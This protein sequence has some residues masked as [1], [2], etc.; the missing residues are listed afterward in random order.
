MRCAASVSTTLEGTTHLLTSP[1][2]AP[3][4]KSDSDDGCTGT[5]EQLITIM[6]SEFPPTPPEQLYLTFIRKS[7][8]YLKNDQNCIKHQMEEI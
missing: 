5:I 2:T 3:K 6:A 7:L 8:N 4:A 1:A